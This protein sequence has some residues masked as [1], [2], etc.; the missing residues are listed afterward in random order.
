MFNARRDVQMKVH[1]FWSRLCFTGK[2]AFSEIN[3]KLPFFFINDRFSL[4]SSN[5]QHEFMMEHKDYDDSSKLI[6]KI[7]SMPPFT[8]HI[9]C[10]ENL[11]GSLSGITFFRNLWSILAK[12]ST[13]IHSW[14]RICFLCGRRASQNG[15]HFKSN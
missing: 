4:S 5:S 2:K 1:N 12:G 13:L 7:A 6:M 14:A 11:S 10:F 15:E 8:R 3:Q 9:K